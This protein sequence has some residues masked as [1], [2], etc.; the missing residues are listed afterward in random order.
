MRMKK[1]GWILLL[2]IAVCLSA[3]SGS[4]DDPDS[5]PD[6]I[7]ECFLPYQSKEELLEKADAIVS[8]KI[9]KV[10]FKR[11]PDSMSLEPQPEEKEI[12]TVSTA[13]VETVIKGD[14]A[15]GRTIRILQKG[16]NK[17][18]IYSGEKDGG[19]YL[20]KGQKKLLFLDALSEEAAAVAREKFGSIF[21]IH[22][23]VGQYTLDDDGNIVEM[24]EESRRLFG[25]IETLEDI[26]AAWETVK[27]QP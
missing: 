5:Q 23:L 18:R 19:G 17:T 27:T 3:C 8:V 26:R 15:V 16:D 7:R 11:M 9:E 21:G 25:P 6:F 1:I 14:L 24:T 4:P 12:N 2:V 22:S 13:R 10:G 20:Q